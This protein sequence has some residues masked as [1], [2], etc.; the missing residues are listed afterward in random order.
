ME[1]IYAK[2]KINS[3]F[4]LE[5]SL[6]TRKLLNIDMPAYDIFY[7]LMVFIKLFYVGIWNILLPFGNIVFLMPI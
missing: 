5:L 7:V 6:R 2:W 3:S 4:P 1:N